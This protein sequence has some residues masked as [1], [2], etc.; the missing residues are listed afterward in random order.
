M[1]ESAQTIRPERRSTHGSPKAVDLNARADLQ[2]PDRIGRWD[3][4]VGLEARQVI[5][6]G[7]SS[8]TR[9]AAPARERPNGAKVS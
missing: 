9:A 5:V 7:G 2:G 6:A 3:R 8:A 1:D 4:S